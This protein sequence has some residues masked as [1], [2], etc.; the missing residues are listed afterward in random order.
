MKSPNNTARSN[1]EQ[2]FRNTNTGFRGESKFSE[3]FLREKF[4]C[5]IPLRSVVAA[6]EQI[7]LEINQWMFSCMKPA[8][9]WPE[10]SV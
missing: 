7:C 5:E 10:I 8:L 2:T 4:V 3:F 9:N 1:H 6:I